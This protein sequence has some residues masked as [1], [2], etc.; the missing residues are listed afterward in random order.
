MSVFVPG[1][2]E[3]SLDLYVRE[4]IPAS[5]TLTLTVLAKEF[6]FDEEDLFEV[7]IVE[8]LQKGFPMITPRYVEEKWGAALV[9]AGDS[10]PDWETGATVTINE[11]Y[12]LYLTNPDFYIYAAVEDPKAPNIYQYVVC[13]LTYIY[14][15]DYEVTGDKP[16]NQPFERLAPVDDNWE[17]EDVFTWPFPELST[18]TWRTV[19]Y[20]QWKTSPSGH[21][22]YT[23]NSRM[24]YL[25]TARP[26]GLP[27]EQPYIFDCFTVVPLSDPWPPTDGVWFSSKGINDDYVDTYAEMVSR[28]AAPNADQRPYKWLGDA[29]IERRNVPVGFNQYVQVRQY[30]YTEEG[31]PKKHP[32]GLG[33]TP[34]FSWPGGLVVESSEGTS[35]LGLLGHFGPRLFNPRK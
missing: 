18:T 2:Y 29:G 7:F 30:P 16:V 6:I 33:G 13:D 4:Y 9:E 11:D 12:L 28:G 31:G 17:K 26:E 27:H 22:R 20:G 25:L 1:D 10:F 21:W 23:V 19:W 35:L 14:L 5:H 3:S 8:Q 15:P 24:L 34:G 32:P